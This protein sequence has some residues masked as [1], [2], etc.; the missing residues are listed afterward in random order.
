ML[1]GLHPLPDLTYSG[2]S[3]R[4]CDTLV[5]FVAGRESVPCSHRVKRS[6]PIGLELCL[7]IQGSLDGRSERT[8]RWQSL[9]LQNLLHPQS[10]NVMP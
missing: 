4:L 1:E 2:G 8:F 3:I 10:E 9:I 5:G 7:E 6:E